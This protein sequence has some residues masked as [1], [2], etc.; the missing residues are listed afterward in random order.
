VWG[1]L[2]R[3]DSLSHTE[4]QPTNTKPFTH[5]SFM[6]HAWDEPYLWSQHTLLEPYTLFF[7]SYQQK[8]VSFLG[9]TKHLY[10]PEPVLNYTQTCIVTPLNVNA[11]NTCSIPVSCCCFHLFHTCLTL[12]FSTVPYLNSIDALAE[13]CCCLHHYL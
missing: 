3:G 7:S 1:N 13:C 9:G 5:S 11:T 4:T 6:I 12:L 10:L 2:V 8:T